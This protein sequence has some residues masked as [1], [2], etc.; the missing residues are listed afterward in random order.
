MRRVATSGF[1]RKRSHVS[2][3]SSE[4]AVIRMMPRMT[5][6]RCFFSGRTSGERFSRTIKMEATTV[7]A[8]AVQCGSP[9][10]SKAR[11]SI[12]RLEEGELV[13]LRRL[14]ERE[15]AGAPERRWRSFRV[16]VEV[17]QMEVWF[18]RGKTCHHV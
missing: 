8:M 1:W 16:A 18:H 7:A 14:A 3:G 4:T 13:K 17:L 6:A 2:T 5:L 10:V 12:L 9:K 15:S 11:D